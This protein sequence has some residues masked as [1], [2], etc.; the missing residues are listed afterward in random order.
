MHSPAERHPQEINGQ[1]QYI[2]ISYFEYLHMSI[3]RMTKVWIS[4]QMFSSKGIVLWSY[5]VF[6]I[7]K[8]G[9]CKFDLLMNGFKVLVYDIIIMI[10]TLYHWGNWGKICLAGTSFDLLLF[11]ENWNDKCR[12]LWQIHSQL[13]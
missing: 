11:G 6:Q 12:W 5:H 8:K 1:N 9:W 2:F 10:L 4:M 7:K 13:L 3:D